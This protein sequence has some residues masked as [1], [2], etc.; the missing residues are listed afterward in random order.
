MA[1]DCLLHPEKPE[2]RRGGAGRNSSEMTPD[3]VLA[4][5]YGF[6]GTNRIHGDKAQSFHI[7][8]SIYVK[9]GDSRVRPESEGTDAF[10]F[11]STQELRQFCLFLEDKQCYK[12][13]LS[14]ESFPKDASSLIVD[15]I[16]KNSH[17]MEV[18]IFEDFLSHA[19]HLRL[20]DILHEKNYPNRLKESQKK[21]LEN[22]VRHTSRLGAFVGPLFTFS[23]LGI[24]SALILCLIF[25]S[26]SL[27]YGLFGAALVLSAGG[28]YLGSIAG[29]L[30]YKY[31]DRAVNKCYINEDTTEA[32]IP[33]ELEA[34]KAG[35]MAEKWT[36]YFS[37][38]ANYATY[39][40]PLYFAAGM[41]VALDEDEKALPKLKT[42]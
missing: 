14:S 6:Q 5:F 21:V 25:G 31:L 27:G 26:S 8:F 22:T 24:N 7:G 41:K 15:A 23:S 37:S 10:H 4:C 38:Y 39:K 11:D 40:H 34:L 20:K 42:L 3:E 2:H 33:S 18:K 35:V 17:I 1:Y 30:R 36:G 28:Y 29:K 9:G 16:E 32:T 13:N 12:I 19:Q